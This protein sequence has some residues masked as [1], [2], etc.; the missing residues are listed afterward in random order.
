MSGAIISD[1]LIQSICIFLAAF[2]VQGIKECNQQQIGSQS[3]TT[4]RRRR[5]YKVDVWLSTAI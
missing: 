4:N 3:K 1:I 5:K 2:C